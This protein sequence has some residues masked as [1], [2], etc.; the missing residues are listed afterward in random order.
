MQLPEIKEREYRFKLALRMGLPIFVLFFIFVLHTFVTTSKNLDI[1]FFIESLVLLFVS[2]YFIFYLIYEGYDSKIT[3]DISKV[4]TRDALYDYL[5]KRLKTK[6]EYTFLL[7]SIDNL[8][9]INSK[10][11][12]KSADKVLYE[13]GQWLCEYLESKNITNFPIGHVNGAEFVVCLQGINSEYK[14][15]LEMLCLKGDEFRIDD[16]EVKISAAI[17]NTNHSRELDYIIENLF[18]LQAQNRDT[19]KIQNNS[20]EINPS[21]L[22]SF[23]ISAIKK[24]K[25]VSLTQNVYSDEKVAIKE[26]FVKLETPS[27]KIIHPKTYTKVL[28]KLRLMLDFDLMVLE[29]NIQNC[30]NKNNILF[31]INISPTSIRN[32][33]FVQKVKELLIKNQDLKNKI[34]FLLYE[35]Q[36]Y[37]HL[38][39]YNNS[40][41]SLRK[42]GILIAIDKLG[43]SHT[44]FL[45]LRDLDIDI[46]RFDTI[47][48]KDLENQKYNS[49]IKGLQTIAND[50]GLK[51]WMKMI[52]SEEQLSEVRKLGVNYKQG[53]YLS[54]LEIN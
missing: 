23:V 36:Y 21:E 35:N 53:I 29:K 20:D 27:G 49:I 17:N 37:S 12:V 18:E 48:S 50:N 22:E 13:I 9:D 15:I 11:G 24:Q 4:F 54:K 3:N 6:D 51:T 47:Y 40:L 10:Y 32:P 7:I 30:K 38:S 16:I 46:V 34:I 44:S 41:Q 39:K 19:K 25:F 1:Y 31:A 14:V 42:A 45:Y 43:S 26:C 52:E 5:N 33:V 28:N 8:N 2:V